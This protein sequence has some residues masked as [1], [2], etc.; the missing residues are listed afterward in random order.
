MGCGRQVGSVGAVSPYRL[1]PLSPG[2][3]RKTI[4]TPN[5]AN[6]STITSAPEVVSGRWFGTNSQNGTVDQRG[7]KAQQK[8]WALFFNRPAAT[9]SDGTRSAASQRNSP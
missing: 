8:V 9:E 5:S 3:A 6:M 7:T 1:G 4:R 2:R